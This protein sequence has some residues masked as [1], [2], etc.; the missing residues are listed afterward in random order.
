MR[1][2]FIKFIDYA[3]PYKCRLI[4]LLI[5]LIIAILFMTIGFFKTILIIICITAGF[6]IGYFFDDKIDFGNVVDK[7]LSRVKG[8]K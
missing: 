5:G 8:D 3:T 7:I 6:V 4:G 1:E 2:L